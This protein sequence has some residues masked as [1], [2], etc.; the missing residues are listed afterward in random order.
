M[1]LFYYPIADSY[2]LVAGVAAAL[3]AIVALVGPG[4]DRV[5]LRRRLHAGLDSLRHHPLGR[6]GNAAADAGLHGDPQGTR[7]LGD[8]D[9]PVAE[10]AG[11]RQPQQQDPLGI[12]AGDAGRIRV[13]ASRPGPRFRDQGLHFRCRDPFPRGSE[14][15]QDRPAGKPVG[16]TDGDWRGP[17]RRA[18]PGERQAAVGDRPAHRRPAAS[19]DPARRVGTGH[20]RQAAASELSGLPGSVWTV[21]RSGRRPGRGGRRLSTAGRRLRQDRNDDPWRDQD[22]RIRQPADSRGIE[23]G[24]ARGQDGNHRP[25]GGQGHGRR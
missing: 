17:G 13:R 12:A 24:D 1:H 3:M 22:Q 25:N 14:R 7:H 9:R 8:P 19:P 4:R 11:P 6:V 10:H 16:P 23:D 15:R 21:A 20:C 2:W 18:Q 5:S